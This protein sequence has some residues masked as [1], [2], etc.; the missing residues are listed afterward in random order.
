MILGNVMARHGLGS[1]V[2]G[3][4]TCGWA[5]SH[6]FSVCW[7]RVPQTFAPSH[8]AQVLIQSRVPPLKKIDRRCLKKV[9]MF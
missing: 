9:T 1:E 6:S 8:R 7:S 5:Q 4:L 3:V 2:A